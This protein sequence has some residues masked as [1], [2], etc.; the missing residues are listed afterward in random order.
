VKRPAGITLDSV[1]KH[2]T[3][4]FGVVRA[5]D[6]IDLELE[7][8]SSLAVTGPSGC[9]KSTLLALIGGLEAPSAGR[10]VVGDQEMSRL[11][12]SQRARLRRDEFG[13]VFQQDNLMP[14]LTAIENVALQLSLHGA[15]D[16]HRGIPELLSELG[17]MEEADKLPDQLSGG[18][19]QRVAVA[20][21]VVKQPCVILADEPTGSL[22][23]ESAVPVIDVLVELHRRAHTTLV[24]VT[25]NAGV[26]ERLDRSLRLRDGRLAEEGIE[27]GP[28]RL[29]R[30]H[31]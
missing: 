31:A 23:P 9:G 30:A 26:A 13:F 25:H 16:D 24:V 18:Q 29:G 15:R 6:G 21:A 4:P 22:D 3:T 7:P 28:P 2:Y 17:L 8:G 11:S 12:D 14:F 27:P 19:R 10:V 20:C 5:L 1:C